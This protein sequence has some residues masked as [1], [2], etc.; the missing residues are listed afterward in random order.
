MFKSESESCLNRVTTSTTPQLQAKKTHNTIKYIT[1][2][3][4]LDLPNEDSSSLNANNNKTICSYVEI[5]L[6]KANNTPKH[7]FKINV[8]SNNNNINS[9][10]DSSA[11]TT[12]KLSRLSS[13][14]RNLTNIISNGTEN[15]IRR[16]SQSNTKQQDALVYSIKN[17]NLDKKDL[18]YYKN[19]IDAILSRRSVKRKIDFSDTIDVRLN[20]KFYSRVSNSCSFYSKFNA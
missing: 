8:T 11:T 9:N 20:W 6:R 10:N 3:Q 5:N 13:S 16:F 17:K 12:P 14:F 19:K 7:E 18:Q 2:K 15:L 4:S 1:K